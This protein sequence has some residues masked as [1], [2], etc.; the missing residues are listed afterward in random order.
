MAISNMQDVA[1]VY[2]PEGEVSLTGFRASL[3]TYAVTVSG[4]AF[5]LRISG[6]ALPEHYSAQDLAVGGLAVHKFSRLLTKGSVTSPLRAPFTEFQAPSGPAEHHEEVRGTHGIRHTIGELV[7][8]PFC[9][10]VWIGTGYVAA[11]VIAPRP[12]RA[13]AAVFGVIGIADFLQHVYCR[14]RTT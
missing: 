14:L 13:W 1:D 8:C 6:R 9:L 4:L 2:D 10:G 12:T 5:A 3:A 7:T 11:L